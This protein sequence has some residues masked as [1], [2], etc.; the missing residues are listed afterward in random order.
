MQGTAFL[1]GLHSNLA[2]QLLPGKS[3]A[4]H[5]GNVGFPG[6]PAPPRQAFTWFS[7][8]KY[9]VFYQVKVRWRGCGPPATARTNRMYRGFGRF[10]S[11]A[12]WLLPGFCQ[13]FSSFPRKHLP[14]YLVNF[15]FPGSHSRWER[16]ISRGI[17]ENAFVH[18]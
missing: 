15:R 16:A 5:Q 4:F 8:G 14:F 3:L 1:V 18:R 6:F 7:P 13:V 9:L 2:N 17:L 10:S 11:L 12:D